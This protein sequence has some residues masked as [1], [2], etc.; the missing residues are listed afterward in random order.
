M[1]QNKKMKSVANVCFY[2]HLRP[3]SFVLPWRY[4]IGIFVLITHYAVVEIEERNGSL[5]LTQTAFSPPLE[6]L[7][8]IAAVG[9]IGL[10]RLAG[11]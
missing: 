6:Y 7:G 8:Q 11:E 2:V 5:S 9:I 1:R 4:E 10:N 3:F